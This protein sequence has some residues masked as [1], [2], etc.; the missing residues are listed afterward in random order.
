MD[1][2]KPKVHTFAHTFWKLFARPSVVKSNL[3]QREY[4]YDN[5]EV[6]ALQIFR[7]GYMI[8]E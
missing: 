3:R 2:S 4:R 1:T 7:G 5:E 6:L 8:H